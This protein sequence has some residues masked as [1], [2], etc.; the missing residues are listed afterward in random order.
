MA[1]QATLIPECVLFL[2]SRRVCQ[3]AMTLVAALIIIDSN[4]Y[5]RAQ[6]GGPEPSRANELFQFEPD[7]PERLVNAIVAADRLQRP[8][9]AR[10]YLRKLRE[11]SRT[12]EDLQRLRQKF[13]IGPFLQFRTNP[14]LHPEAAELLMAINDASRRPEISEVQLRELVQKLGTGDSGAADAV[15]ELLAAEEQAVPALLAADPATPAGKMANRILQSSAR[16]LRFGLLKALPTVDEATQIRV[17]D[18]LGTTVD[19]GIIPALVRWQFAPDSPPSV[20]AAAGHAIQE[21]AGMQSIP[22][23]A[24]QAVRMLKQA[25]HDELMFAGSRF[26]PQDLPG[27]VSRRISEDDRTAAV[28]RSALY[29][30]DA[31]AIAPNDSE[32]VLL[33]QLS[34]FA[35]EPPLVQF[36]DVV[37]N[38]GVESEQLPELLEHA[39]AARNTAAVIGVLKQWKL[40]LTESSESALNSAGSG[41]LQR[42]IEFPDP[43]VRLIAAQLASS[44]KLTVGEKMRSEIL[45][46][47]QNGSPIPEAVVIDADESRATELADVLNDNGFATVAVRRGTAGFEAAVQQL[48]CELILVEANCIRW[49]LSLTIANLRADARTRRTPV[50]IYG[51]D[52]AEASALSLARRYPGIWFLREPLGAVT[53]VDRLRISNVDLPLLS[54]QDRIDMRSLA[55]LPSP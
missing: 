41:A 4:T 37:R 53:L 19:P 26:S 33:V 52:T 14:E 48:N 32:A 43:R 1:M 38:T 12:T 44:S 23:S 54:E 3:T 35:S 21:L 2:R 49:D 39:L 40:H 10:R 6:S 20:A 15:A 9:D 8:L 28:S 24:D 55:E 34:Q 42:A 25:I 29:A 27:I 36:H 47:V 13:G 45:K 5:V 31:A 51:P 18:L 46:V 7:T 50:V 11:Q 17:L 22:E 16:E 30:R